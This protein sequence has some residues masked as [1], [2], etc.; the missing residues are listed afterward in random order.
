MRRTVR[1]RTSTPIV[2]TAIDRMV[3]APVGL[4]RLAEAAIAAGADPVRSLPLF[5]EA[6]E[7]LERTPPTVVLPDT[8]HGLA[9][10]PQVR[11]LQHRPAPGERLE[12]LGGQG[13][14]EALRELAR[15]G[16]APLQQPVRLRGDGGKAIRD[17][18]FDRIDAISEGGEAYRDGLDNVTVYR[19]D[20]RF[21]GD[22]TLWS[23]HGMIVNAQGTLDLSASALPQ[24]TLAAWSVTTSAES[25][26]TT[27]S[28]RS[29]DA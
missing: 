10:L 6:A 7:A 15:L 24:R 26:S 27:A 9:A 16:L 3:P 2:L 28:R 1:A 29:F 17:R 22:R 21:A 11:P 5:I 19:G 23:G 4:L 20:G 25:A 8:A 18:V 14:V 13:V 12:L